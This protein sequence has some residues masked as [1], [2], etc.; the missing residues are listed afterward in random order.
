MALMQSRRRDEPPR[1]VKPLLSLHALVAIVGLWISSLTVPI[2]AAS[3]PLELAVHVPARLDPRR[4]VH[5]ATVCAAEFTWPG[6][7]DRRLCH[8]APCR[9]TAL[10]FAPMPRHDRPTATARCVPRASTPWALRPRR[11]P[12]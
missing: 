6:E 4:P 8:R 2:A 3:T 11:R 7:F 5:S 9:K 1:P 10:Q 12:P